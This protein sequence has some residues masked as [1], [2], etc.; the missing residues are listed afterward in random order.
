M[1]P[2]GEQRQALA[3]VAPALGRLFDVPAS[4]VVVQPN[5]GSGADLLVRVSGH[6]FL[7]EVLASSE[8]GPVNAHAQGVLAAARERRSKVTPLLA[9]PFMKEAG[10]RACAA[11]GVGWFDLSGNAHLVAPG[12]RVII[13][14]QPNRFHK[15]GRP[16]SVFAPKS[17][18]VVR[19]LLTE[20]G[21]ART[22]REIARAAG[23]TEGFVSRIA[24]RLIQQDYVVRDPRGALRVKDAGLLLDAWRDEYLFDR[25]QVIRGH[26]AA[27]TGDALAR[28]VGDRLAAAS[29]EHAATGL[30]AAW[31]MTHFASFR[32]AT[33]FIAVEPTQSL[34]AA[35]D[36]REDARGA[37]LWLVVPND[38]GVF[39]GSEDRDGL[40]CVHPVQAYLDL[41]GH[42]ERAAEA[43]DRLR[44]ELLRW[45][46]NA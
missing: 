38:A 6:A 9:V 27:R 33:F 8:P 26:V 37:N 17:S 5:R 19:C 35:L 30:A 4:R 14:G 22:Q 41:K 40:R 21:R 32:V 2:P 28:M 43:A 42:P 3:E 25:H 44:T 7:V 11:V 24:A 16:A 39:Y 36:F 45:K 18:R 46:R 29:A 20:P 13:D 31:Q 23:M 1:L 12:L 15:R 10:R 34:K